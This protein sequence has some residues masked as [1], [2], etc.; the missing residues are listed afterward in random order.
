VA[1]EGA[2]ALHAELA[3]RDPLTA[4]R[5]QPNDAPRLL[6][7]LEV[8]ETSGESIGAL[9]AATKPALAREDWA[10]LA[11]TP[12]R[13]ALYGAIDARFEA[14]LAAGA[15]EEVRAF[16]ALG[17]DP[18]L[19]S[20]KAHGAPAL[21]AHLRGEL[22]L[23]AAAEIAKRDTRRYAKRQFTWIAG[24]MAEWELVGEVELN[25]RIPRSL[26]FLQP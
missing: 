11:L 26:A 7:A 18:A 17:L 9:Q 16:A 4:A 21:M 20:M 3:R 12:D 5:L 13:A 10:G 25:Q 23:V 6:R 22:S 2:P 24:Q 8:L 1:R 19:P 15:L 14:M